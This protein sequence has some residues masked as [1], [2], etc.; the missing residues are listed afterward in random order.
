[1]S[2]AKRGVSKAKAPRKKTAR[3]KAAGKTAEA[4]PRPPKLPPHRPTDYKPEYVAIAKALCAFGATDSDLAEEF[5]VRRSTIHNWRATHPDFREACQVGKEAAD[6]RVE[7]TLY[8]CAVGWANGAPDVMAIRFWLKNRRPHQWR[9][10][11]QHELS[12]PDGGPIETKTEGG[13]S[14]REAARMIAELLMR[15]AETTAPPAEQA[16]GGE[17]EADAGS[18]A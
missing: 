2:P 5:E 15:G 13:M 7:R 4:A 17:L 3:K 11:S 1:M 12:G 14:D 8:E 9:D 10:S 18:D 6:I 16:P